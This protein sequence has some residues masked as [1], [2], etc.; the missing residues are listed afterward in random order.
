MST[1]RSCGARVT[2]LETAGGKKLIVDEDPA[3]NGNIIAVGGMA[4]VCRNA[5]AAKAALKET[6]GSEDGPRYISHFAT[7]PDA[8]NWRRT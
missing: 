1:C 5:E 6:T 2:W 3:E 8:G 7:C 4:H